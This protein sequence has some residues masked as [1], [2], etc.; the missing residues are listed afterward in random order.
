MHK[1]LEID[2]FPHFDWSEEGVIETAYAQF[3]SWATYFA[4]TT[5]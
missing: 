5:W 4:C 1:K 3:L 2:V